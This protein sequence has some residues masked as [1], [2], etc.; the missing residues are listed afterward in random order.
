MEIFKEVVNAISGGISSGITLDIQDKSLI[1]VIN[2]RKEF[3][4]KVREME[5]KLDAIEKCE[6]A[7]RALAMQELEH[8][9]DTARTAL[10]EFKDCWQERQDGSST[11]HLAKEKNSLLQ[12]VESD[13]KE[14]ISKIDQL[15]VEKD[16]PPIESFLEAREKGRVLS[17]LKISLNDV[18]SRYENEDGEIKFKTR[19][20][21]E[22]KGEMSAIKSQC[23]EITKGLRQWR[24]S[25]EA[26]GLPT[27][28][29]DFLLPKERMGQE[30]IT[31]IN[32]HMSQIMSGGSHPEAGMDKIQPEQ[33]SC[34]SCGKTKIQNYMGGGKSIV[35]QGLDSE[36]GDKVWYVLN[37]LSLVNN[38]S[39]RFILIN[40]LNI[41][42]HFSG[43]SY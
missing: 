33:E 27:F 5:A 31:T 19:D 18:I 11:D 40:I 10:K 37:N 23:V 1:E 29:S 39:T 22:A 15:I 38:S 24:M 21:L 8:I 16:A 17:D 28:I 7:N 35:Q 26:E 34:D 4:Q 12:L 2:D 9:G 14:M 13:A 30:I 43:A 6:Q 36:P 3:R 42:F 32:N 25:K 20:D 41:N